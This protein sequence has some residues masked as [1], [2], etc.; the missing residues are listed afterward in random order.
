M[1]RLF[2]LLILC[3]PF[4]ALADDRGERLA[5]AERYAAAA[6]MD[7]MLDDAFREMSLTL[8]EAQRDAFVAAM[9]RTIDR[10]LLREVM[11]EAMVG[12]FTAEELDALADFYGSEVGR[13]VMRKF[14]EYMAAFM[15]A[16]E[17]ILVQAAQQ[18]R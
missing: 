10:G 1:I 7:A 2:L 11:M 13:S 14:G 4:S 5:A 8:P 15:P 9:D 17:Q 3:W 18:A 6:D 12:V 16:L